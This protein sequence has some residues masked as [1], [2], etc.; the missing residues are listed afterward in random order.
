MSNELEFIRYEFGQGIDQYFVS[1]TLSVSEYVEYNQWIHFSI[2]EI[3][4]DV[5]QNSAIE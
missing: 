5:F 4:G 3:C 1:R 2:F